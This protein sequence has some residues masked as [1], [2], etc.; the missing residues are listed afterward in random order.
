M[1]RLAADENLNNAIVRGILR[2]KPDTDIVR[3]QDAGLSGAN[4]PTVLAWAA[5][6]GRVL[7]TND[8]TTITQYAYERVAAGQAMPGVI[9]ISRAVPIGVAI[10]E[11]ILLLE[12][13]IADDWEGQVLFLP[14]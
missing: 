5:E 4:D 6:Q 11:I 13:S 12:C 10:D 2:R 7:L 8:V 9:E 1:L 3:I 14:L